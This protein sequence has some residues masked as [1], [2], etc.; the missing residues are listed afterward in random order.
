MCLNLKNMSQLLNCQMIRVH[1][2]NLC[3]K[4]FC[5][6]KFNLWHGRLNMNQCLVSLICKWYPN[7]NS[8]K[9]QVYFKR[10]LI[11]SIGCGFCKSN[12]CIESSRTIQQRAA[13]CDVT[14]NDLDTDEC[15]F[16][17]LDFF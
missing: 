4:I 2:F 9:N 17:R 15:I 13:Q 3:Y 10:A 16:D 12:F 8:S 6:F 14:F 7:E 11:Y 1:D 5:V